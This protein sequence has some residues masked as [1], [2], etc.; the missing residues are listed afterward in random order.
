[1]EDIPGQGQ[2][3]FDPPQL[4]PPLADP[5]AAQLGR[6][7]AQGHLGLDGRRQEHGQRLPFVRHLDD[8]VV[9]AVGGHELTVLEAAGEAHHAHGHRAPVG[10]VEHSLRRALGVKGHLPKS[11]EGESVEEDQPGL[12]S[13]G[14]RGEELG[15]GALGRRAARAQFHANHRRKAKNGRL[16]YRRGHLR[17]G[18]T[19]IR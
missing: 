2:L 14:S 4:Q 15:D 1:M 18:P 7:R 5:L 9:D 6:Q 8:V 11:L 19:P 12:V 13:Q 10:A 3:S 16:G 17:C